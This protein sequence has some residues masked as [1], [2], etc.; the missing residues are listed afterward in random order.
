MP[1]ST[2]IGAPIEGAPI[3]G[4]SN[5]GARNVGALNVGAPAAING[6]HEASTAAIAAATDDIDSTNQRA[7]VDGTAA[8]I[9]VMGVAVEDKEVVATCLADWGRA[10]RVGTVW[11]VGVP[12]PPATAAA[13]AAVLALHY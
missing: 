13:W 9:G 6:I 7:L 5:V 12:L 4:A 10:P 3:E 1:A 2:S 11:P 8:D